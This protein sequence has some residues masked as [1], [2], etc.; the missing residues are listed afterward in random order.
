MWHVSFRSGVATLRTAIHLLLT[1]FLTQLFNDFKQY[2]HQLLQMDP[3][4][5]L[6]HAHRA[7]DEG[8]RS[9]R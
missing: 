9:V 8:G 1:Y 3:R 6:P 4:D 2:M 7:V 5:P